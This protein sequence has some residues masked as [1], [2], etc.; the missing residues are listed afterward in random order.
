MTH[1]APDWDR[2]LSPAEIGKLPRDI[3]FLRGTT[4]LARKVELLE[5]MT[6]DFGLFRV[7]LDD[8]F[9]WRPASL[10][11]WS[12]PHLGIRSWTDSNVE[13]HA[14]RKDLMDRYS[15]AIQ[16]LKPMKS[17]AI[18]FDGQSITNDAVLLNLVE[19]QFSE[20]FQSIIDAQKLEIGNLKKQVVCLME[21]LRLANKQTGDTPLASR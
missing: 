1:A 3:T 14:A 12:L 13:K 9:P 11:R 2:D 15:D 20:K 18:K 8:R 7:H 17:L 4:F 6:I 5:K 19:R 10:R 21:A 16:K